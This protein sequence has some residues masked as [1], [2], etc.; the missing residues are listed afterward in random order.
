MQ[1]VHFPK[2]VVSSDVNHIQKI[3]FGAS[4][5]SA[6]A[7]P[8][9]ASLPC[10]FAEGQWLMRHIEISRHRSFLWSNEH[11]TQLKFNGSIMLVFA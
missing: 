11:M 1:N 8:V 7:L 10:S 3:N 9:A 5:K 2:P 4:L 6:E